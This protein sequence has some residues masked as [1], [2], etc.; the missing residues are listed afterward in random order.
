MPASAPQATWWQVR[1]RGSPPQCPQRPRPPG[2]SV[3]ASLPSTP[4]MCRALPFSLHGS[5][6]GSLFPLIFLFDCYPNCWNHL[7]GCPVCAC[8]CVCCCVCICVRVHVCAFVYVCVVCAYVYVCA[9]SVCVLP[10]L[11]DYLPRFLF[12]LCA[13]LKEPVFPALLSG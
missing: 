12:L 13:A 2:P 11:I 3:C 4:E 9:R 6:P 7:Y 5:I 1:P 8:V 10:R